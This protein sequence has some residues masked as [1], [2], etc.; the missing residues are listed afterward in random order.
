MENKCKCGKEG[1]EE[2][3]C[4]YNEDVY[5]DSESVC[6]CCSDCINICVDDI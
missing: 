2:H 4:P 3:S 6:N 5:G 1:N